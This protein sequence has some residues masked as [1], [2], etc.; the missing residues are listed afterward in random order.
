[1]ATRNHSRAAPWTI[2]TRSARRPAAYQVHC[3]VGNG[4]CAK[5]TPWPSQDSP[6]GD[7]PWAPRSA[8]ERSGKPI[9]ALNQE[10][11][12]LAPSRHVA[13]NVH[14]P[15]GARTGALQR[16]TTLPSRRLGSV[17]SK[18]VALI[19]SVQLVVLGAETATVSTLT[20]PTLAL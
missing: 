15:F 20:A 6:A 14:T 9:S 1:M 5:Q 19:C 10:P 11:A 17:F 7:V 13:V 12:Q 4:S 18:S 2:P 3:A 16:H 8:P